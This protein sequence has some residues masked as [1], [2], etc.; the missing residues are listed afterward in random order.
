MGRA[1]AII[2]GVNSF[3][4]GFAKALQRKQMMDAEIQ[5]QREKEARQLKFLEEQFRLNSMLNDIDARRRQEEAFRKAKID[6]L[7]EMRKNLMKIKEAAITSGYV[8]TV[9]EIDRRLAEI[10]NQISSIARAPIGSIGEV[11]TKS[12][13]A[14]EAPQDQS[15]VGAIQGALGQ[16]QTTAPSRLAESAQ[17][18]TSIGQARP[19][20]VFE[21]EQPSAFESS[22]ELM[23]A[24]QV[25]EEKSQKAKAILADAE[26]TAESISKVKPELS[27]VVYKKLNAIRDAISRGQVEIASSANEELRK[28]FSRTAEKV[29]S[30]SAELST[31]LLKRFVEDVNQSKEERDRIETA[32]NNLDR[33]ETI[34]TQAELTRADTDIGRLMTQLFSFLGTEIG[35]LSGTTRSSIGAIKSATNAMVAKFGKGLAPFSNVDAENISQ[36]ISSMSP[37]PSQKPTQQSLLTSIGH[38]YGM[39][40]SFRYQY[41]SLYALNSEAIDKG[42]D[43]RDINKRLANIRQQSRSVYLKSMASFMNR[44]IANNPNLVLPKDVQ[45]RILRNFL[46]ER[47]IRAFKRN[48]SLLQQAKEEL[49]SAFSDGLDMIVMGQRNGR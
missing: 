18:P 35:P 15:V 44:F 1:R 32:I 42:F 22:P 2:S 7:S 29:P 27:G 34:P 6:E 11:I 17:V 38:L 28:L 37:D 8:G 20:S 39:L 48:Q 12:L 21:P 43:A 49:G 26:S 23:F 13:G 40:N 5:L 41:D 3:A 24:S 19:K 33:V 25:A 45:A 46:D 47:V 9:E 4:E 14:Q 10:S 36:A 30:A 31:Q 16:G